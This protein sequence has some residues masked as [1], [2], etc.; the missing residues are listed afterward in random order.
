MIALVASAVLA[1]NPFLLE[2]LQHEKELEFEKCVQRLKQAVTQWKNSP[3]ELKEIELHAGLCTFNLGDRKR[4]AEHFRLALRIDATTVLPEFTSP[5]IVELFD[6][7][8]RALDAQTPLRDD[9]LQALRE[10]TPVADQPPPKLEPR[11]T[12]STPS[13]LGSF[14][15]R[16]AVPL[17]LGVVSVASAVTGLV[18]GLRAQAVATEANAARFE[19]DFYRLGADAT[20]LATGATL[21]WVLAGASAIGAVVTWW[22]MGEPPP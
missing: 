1:T 11:V 20:G 2:G 6:E 5:K 12:Q 19:S 16:R 22:V 4:A 10:D 9:E 7:V 17:S 13:P 8:K 18:L 3:E 14:V 21:A 15:T